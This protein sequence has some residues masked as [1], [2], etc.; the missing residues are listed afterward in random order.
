M[1]A[2]FTRITAKIAAP[3]VGIGMLVGA[4]AIFA[5]TAPQASANPASTMAEQSCTT[6]TGVGAAKAGAPDLMTR[7]GQIAASAPTAPSAAVSCS[8]H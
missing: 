2:T 5:L 6:S 7:A 1:S 8:G 4:T 3:A